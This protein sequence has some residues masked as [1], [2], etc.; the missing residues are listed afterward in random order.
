MQVFLAASSGRWGRKL[1]IGFLI[2]GFYGG[3]LFLERGA[4][5]A[6]PSDVSRTS[7]PPRLADESPIAHLDGAGAAADFLEPVPG[8]ESATQARRNSGPTFLLS[9]HALPNRSGETV[10]PDKNSNCLDIV[11]PALGLEPRTC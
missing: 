2:A 4:F 8:R 6:W 10:E 11:E 9:T 5:L 1:P 3:Q 7:G